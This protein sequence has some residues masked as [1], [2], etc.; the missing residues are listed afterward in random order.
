MT[1]WGSLDLKGMKRFNIHLS[2][3]AFSNTSLDGNPGAD[4]INTPPYYNGDTVGALHAAID[5]VDSSV[6]DS[7]F[8]YQVQLFSHQD[9]LEDSSLIPLI[10]PEAS[11]TDVT[12][13]R[14]QYFKNFAEGTALCWMNFYHGELI[15]SGLIQQQIDDTL[16]VLITVEQVKV[17]PDGNIFRVMLCDSIQPTGF[18]PELKDESGF[19]S[20]LPDIYDFTGK[21]IP[22]NQFLNSIS[23]LSIKENE[24]REG[25]YW[26]KL[27]VD[28]VPVFFKWIKT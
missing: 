15:Q 11:K 6:V 14:A 1:A 24:L 20:A 26:V 23:D 10:L 25:F 13:K 27:D 7:S 16:P 21:K 17:F 5:W 8:I 18:I 28:G 4:D 22:N 12:I 9:I 19:S 2:Y 3:L